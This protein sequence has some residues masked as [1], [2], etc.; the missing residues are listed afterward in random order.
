MLCSVGEGKD[1]G[2]LEGADGRTVGVPLREGHVIVVPWAAVDRPLAFASR[3]EVIG[4]FGERMRR[5]A[6]QIVS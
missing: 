4:Q 1:S 6:Q 5:A 3:P 2:I